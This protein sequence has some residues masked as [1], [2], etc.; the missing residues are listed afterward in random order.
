MRYLP[1][2]LITIAGCGAEDFDII[3]EN[4]IRKGSAP[5]ISISTELQGHVDNFYDLATLYGFNPKTVYKIEL[6][7]SVADKDHPTAIGLCYYGTYPKVL[8]KRGEDYEALV[9]HEMIHC[10]LEYKKHD[11]IGIM[12]SSMTTSPEYAE[13]ALKDWLSENAP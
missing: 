3:F 2:L 9:Y 12:T 1:L 7:D 6:M 11:G 4:E 13:E 8:I 10:S 5:D